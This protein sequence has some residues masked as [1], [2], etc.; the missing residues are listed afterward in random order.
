MS[1]LS[2]LRTSV[3]RLIN[4]EDSSDSHFTDDEINDYLNQATM[5]LGTQMEWPLQTSIASSVQDQALYSLPS[6]FIS[7]VDVYFD[8][9]KLDVLE[10]ED[11]SA[12]NP[13]WQDSDSGTPQYI[14]KA[15]NAVIGL[16][17]PPNSANSNLNIQIQY[18]QV[19]ATLS[20]DSDV[21]D[22]HTAFQMCLPF[23]AAF[24]CETK[25]G[26]DK[27]A[28]TDLTYY[29]SHKKALMSKLQRFSDDLYR[30]RWT[31]G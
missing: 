21:P 30:F 2:T 3:R 29:E 1:S 7:L 27:K 16:Y 8:N 19:P 11:L 4:E 26:N 22:I 23:Y 13:R 12:I 20:G 24:L 18:I 9:G 5:F 28:Q 17:P 6:D 31:T 15:D 14:Y 10:R 25:L